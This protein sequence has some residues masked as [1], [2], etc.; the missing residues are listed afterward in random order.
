[1]NT[2]TLPP[3]RDG[4][5]SLHASDP[6]LPWPA[7]LRAALAADAGER[8]LLVA[9][10]LVPDVASLHLLHEALSGLPA[11][12]ALSPAD[13]AEVRAT[14]ALEAGEE[15]AA[16]AW[17]FAPHQA[18]A[19]PLDPRCALWR[20]SAAERLLREGPQAHLASAR[21]PYLALEL[22]PPLPGLP[23]LLRR[24]WCPAG[25]ARRRPQPTLA[26]RDGRPV[27]LHVLHDWGGG[28]ERF[29]RDQMHH[30]GSATH[31]ALLSRGRE[32][33]AFGESL[34]LHADLDAPPLRVWACEPAVG[35]MADRHPVVA[36]ALAETLASFG[37]S[38]LRVS[39]LIGS[40]LDVLRTGLPTAFVLHDAFPFWPLLDDEAPQPAFDPDRLRAGLAA[41][42]RRFHEHDPE[43]WRAW[44]AATIAA[45]GAP[46]ISLVAPSRAAAARLEALL[47]A[48]LCQRIRV[49]PHGLALPVT[50]RPASRRPGPL[51][52]L[53]PGRLAGGKGERLLE[54]LL[55]ITPPDIDWYF[56]GGGERA[57][58]F[59]A[60][61]GGRALPDYMVSELPALVADFDPDLALLPSLLPETFGYV[62]S[63]MQ[64]L[65]VPVLAAAVGAYAERLAGA[66]EGLRPLPPSADAF[67][68]ALA[69]WAAQPEALPRRSAPPPGLAD[70]LAAWRQLQPLAPPRPRPR[71]EDPVAL[72]QH[73]QGM[74]IG[75]ADDLAQ[76]R[77]EAYRAYD[78]DTADLIQQRDIAVAQTQ[79]LMQELTQAHG[80]AEHLR[81][82]LERQTDDG[83]RAEV[84]R[85]AEERD[86]AY[87]FYERDTADLIRQRDV[88]LAQRDAAQA[89]L[90]RLQ[91]IVAHPW[92][93]WPRQLRRRLVDA[94]LV[95]R[96]HLLHGLDLG[97]RGLRSL[98]QRG[99]AATLAAARRRFLDRPAAAPEDAA[100]VAEAPLCFPHTTG[101]LRASIVIPVHGKLDY[102]LACLRSLIAAGLGDEAEVIVV[103]DASPDASGEVLPR[104]PGL[105]YHRNRENLGFVGS[106]NAGAA[107]ARGDYLVFLNNDTT[108][109][110][111]WLTALLATFEQHPDTG[112][113]GALLVYPDGRLQE[114]GGIVFSDGSGWNYGRF[115]DPQHPAYTFVREADYCSGAAIA[116][117]RTLFERLGGFD[118]R[119]APAYYEDTD[120][121]MKVRE[122]GLKVRVQPAA[123]VVHHE[124]VTAGTDT[125]S[126]VKAYQV[127]NQQ[128]FLERWREVLQ[129]RHPS[130]TQAPHYAAQHRA[131]ARVLVIDAT[132]PMPDRD[133]GSVR[134]FELLRLLVEEGCAVS[135]FPENG[136]DDGRYT[137]AL[138]DLGVEAWTQPWLGSVPDWLAKHGARFQ[139][140][141]VSR[142][143]VLSPLL[144]LLR[145]HAPQARI[146]FDTVDLHHLRELREA[147]ERRDP[148]LK[149][150]AERTREAELAL[151]RSVDRTWVVSPVEQAL[152]AKELPQARVDVV[153]NIHRVRGRGPGMA[154][155]SGLLFVG[156]YRHPPNVDAALWLAHEI[157]PR[158]RAVR[159]DIH[160]SLVG[161][162]APPEVLALGEREGIHV[163]GHVP[164]LVPLL[165][166][167]RFSVAPL[168]YGA[169][170]KGKVN[171]ALA[172][173][174]PVVATSCAV[175]GMGLSHGVDVL[176]A[177][178]A[179]SFAA[180]LLAAYEDEPLWER[181]V[182]G[183]LAN[184]ER[185]FSPERARQTLRA[186][187][188]ELR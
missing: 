71:A 143:Y 168:R 25:R 21:L 160:L 147:E 12:D 146:V 150:H 104:I 38:A 116:L 133:S 76:E 56:A 10:G 11:L 172:H 88:A 152:L 14:W 129:R 51:R 90:A 105:R 140:I 120:L 19:G 173:G 37:V 141:I 64:A 137:Q 121:A 81:Q 182:A 156:G 57:E 87:A 3:H 161:S 79:T 93:R 47:P 119:Y 26:G 52:V 164:D 158:L 97:R 36:A 92:V 59:A 142:H 149:R 136:L 61:T 98:R 2:A 28:V 55:P 107:L 134:L 13:A 167:H 89:E 24:G 29:V 68:A 72:L 60:R 4:G 128:R 42:G 95:L 106:C 126:G 166:A 5:L 83:I 175:E 144:P 181:L 162:E 50:P 123:V 23:P 100:P 131:R 159:P 86:Q 7:R 1:M 31:L 127:R 184:T 130:P 113:A 94:L 34:A 16:F 15:A 43:V 8:L 157:L 117:P 53:V 75:L 171:Q 145:R 32:G 18:L 155:R 177:D 169:G 84:R 99:L 132:T 22:G 153:S 109:R 108:V 20:R 40:S 41:P 27:V 188:S 103:D 65:G 124:G 45:L 91:A 102:T 58:R 170:V 33:R 187:F 35:D 73:A 139:L 82:T 17:S 122:A 185:E 114:S 180:T 77:D 115:E 163:H 66:P 63:E 110:P 39:S 111:G 186:I 70:S 151:M 101:P 138:R 9:P 112:L 67:A 179:E 148:A 69:H 49:L 80:H 125:A 135:F 78:R 154:A 85:L 118:E 176:V 46:G 96:Y 74:L 6:V 44:S 48:A 54:A 178:D 174:L 62:L 183:G 165:D 30:D